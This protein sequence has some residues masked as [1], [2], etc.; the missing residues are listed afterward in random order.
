MLR[1]GEAAPLPAEELTSSSA[2]T[3]VEDIEVA[4]FSDPRGFYAARKA[5]LLS[6]VSS[7]QSSLLGD[8]TGETVAAPDDPIGA[9]C[10]K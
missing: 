9:I 4:S 5:A 7:I 3:I 1:R 6:E 8:N 2:S 10:K